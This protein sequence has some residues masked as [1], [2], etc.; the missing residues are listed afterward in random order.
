MVTLVLLSTHASFPPPKISLFITVDVTF[1][2]TSPTLALFP[3]PNTVFIVLLSIK[4]FVLLTLPPKLL[5]PYTVSIV[6]IFN[7][8]I[9]ASSTL[10]LLFE[11]P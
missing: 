2:V 7:T 3:P 10:P 1:K 5:P 4:R 9:F 6:Y 11:P 8:L